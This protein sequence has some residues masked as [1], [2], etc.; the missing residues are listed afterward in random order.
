MPRS[1]A[2]TRKS[3]GAVPKGMVLKGSGGK[4]AQKTTKT[5]QKSA[6]SSARSSGG[7]LYSCSKCGKNYSNSAGLAQHRY[8]KHP[9]DSM[10]AIKYPPETTYAEFEKEGKQ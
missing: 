6:S 5:A 10:A 3:S 2:V 7:Q 9:N 1:K 4:A 8:R